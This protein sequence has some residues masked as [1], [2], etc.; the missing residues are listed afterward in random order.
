MSFLTLRVY[1]SDN[2]LSYVYTAFQLEDTAPEMSR[3]SSAKAIEAG[4]ISVRVNEDTFL[5]Q[6]NTED[7]PLGPFRADLIFTDDEG[8]ETEVINGRIKRS[9][10][11]HFESLSTWSIKLIDD[12]VDYFLELLENT[13]IA[14]GVGVNFVDVSTALVESDG[15]VSTVTIRWYDLEA[16]WTETV[17]DVGN[18]FVEYQALRQF[19]NLSIVYNNG[20]VDSTIT[21]KLPLY[22]TAPEGV[23]EKPNWNGGQIFDALKALLGWR[24]RAEFSPYPEN[25]VTATILT[26]RFPAPLVD[27]PVIDGLDRSNGPFGKTILEQEI[28]DFG[29]A[30]RNG[31]SDDP[32]HA[33][34]TT[35]Q[36]L[37][38]YAS[39]RS[40]VDAEGRPTNR[41]INTVP[42]Y[43]PD[44]D[45]TGSLVA[46]QP[47]P[48]AHP[49]Y[50]ED[51][52]YAVPGI[53]A[54]NKIYIC[55]FQ[56]IPA[57]GVRM[58]VNR[59]PSLPASGQLGQTA[60]YWAVEL[61]KNFETSIS[62]LVQLSGRIDFS[63]IAPL[64]VRPIVGEPF[65]GVRAAERDWMVS[66]LK[67]RVDQMEA[68]IVLKRIENTP[69]VDIDLPIV[70]PP[71]PITILQVL[72]TESPQFELS[73][74]PPDP[75]CG[76]QLPV[77]YQVSLKK[78]GES[79]FTI[80]ATETG[81]THDSGT[82][83]S[84]G[85][86]IYTWCIK[87]ITAAGDLSTCRF[88]SIDNPDIGDS[89]DN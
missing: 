5:G 33:T 84:G 8:T 76:Q 13:P 25:I 85:F 27:L 59:A 89:I 50:T 11:T 54:D 3:K 26:D 79:V 72:F 17:N 38:L 86:G 15:G 39:V 88:A 4:T 77:S 34:F 16:L 87:S 57:V 28:E 41:G 68:D 36:S 42:L 48:T 69:S 49:N 43:L 74:Q 78:P 55:A 81:L 7:L 31:T 71:K 10:I 18:A 70:C 40:E 2:S 80:V 66:E 1:D 23:I 58:V 35:Q 53:E 37:A 51:V 61:F 67:W 73:W 82:L 83:T 63:P 14:S 20:G 30:F 60:E 6:S 44:I 75:G 52:N 22:V 12:S 62:S 47:D 46:Y 45:T 32:A 9:N 65:N 24:I 29:F 56:D 21:R 64:S 19:F